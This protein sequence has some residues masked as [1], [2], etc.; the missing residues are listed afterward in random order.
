[1]SAT[2]DTS[3]LPNINIDNHVTII[4]EENLPKQK[5]ISFLETDTPIQITSPMTSPKI[6]YLVTAKHRISAIEDRLVKDEIHFILYNNK[7]KSAALKIRLEKKG[8][9]VLMLNADEKN[10]DEINEQLESETIN[11]KYNVI[12]VTTYAVEGLSFNN[13][14]ITTFHIY[15]RKFPAAALHQLSARSRKPKNPVKIFQYQTPGHRQKIINLPGYNKLYKEAL[16]YSEVA[17][18]FL[19]NSSFNDPTFNR[20]SAT[21]SIETD[22]NHIFKAFKDHIR[23][24]YQTLEFEPSDLGI[25]HII[26][27]IDSKKECH[28]DSYFI[29]KM[30]DLGWEVVNLGIVKSKEASI[31]DELE[32]I[33]EAKIEAINEV[34]KN[35]LRP[36]LEKYDLEQF[37]ML[38]PDQSDMSISAIVYRQFYSLIN[39]LA[40]PEDAIKSIKSGKKAIQ[41]IFDF[42]RDRRGFI[43][44]FLSN[45]LKVG[46]ILDTATKHKIIEP[47]NRAMKKLHGKEFPIKRNDYG[48]VTGKSSSAF[49]NRFI[50]LK[51]KRIKVVKA[52]G[53]KSTKWINIVTSLQAV[54]YKFT[55]LD[56]SL[57]WWND[58]SKKQEHEKCS[59]LSGDIFFLI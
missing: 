7:E 3:L 26:N 40:D 4:R 33:Q 6:C 49:L 13:P 28:R 21:L 50:T 41:E 25:A 8:F 27:E 11:E 32:F 39:A 24:N 38:L 12:L 59:S 16:Q 14:N 53:S 18:S 34:I 43:Y 30:N 42:N 19:K 15:E 23:P 1:M 36:D 55:N 56:E 22:R 31:K 48:Q 9:T 5:S 10:N 57:F 47:L 52:D 46:D 51:S 45:T 58:E 29:S 35:H 37:H 2:I 20:K 54:N 17:N 44:F